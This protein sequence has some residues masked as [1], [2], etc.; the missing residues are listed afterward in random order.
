MSVSFDPLSCR[1]P[2]QR[3]VIYGARGMVCA[4]QPLA[5]QAGLDIL[6]RGGN[7]VD[8]AIATAACLGAG[9]DIERS[10]RGRLLPH[11]A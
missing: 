11:L 3:R 4:S 5:A 1:F 8:A 2:S 10:G 7:A 6:R 9:T